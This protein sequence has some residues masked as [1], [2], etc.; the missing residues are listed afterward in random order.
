MD[1]ETVPVTIHLYKDQVERITKIVG[2]RLVTKT[3]LIRKLIEK[4]L[5]EEQFK[6]II[7]NQEE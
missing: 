4:G 1:R 7:G 3:A 5:E 6:L 2:I